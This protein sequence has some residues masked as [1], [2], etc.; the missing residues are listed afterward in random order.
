MSDASPSSHRPRFVVHSYDQ[1]VAALQAASSHDRAIE[2]LSATGAARAAGAGWWRELVE[3]ASAAVPGVDAV[4][5]LDCA[6]EPGLALAALREGVEAVS[7]DGDGP[8]WQRVADIARQS[9]A[10]LRRADH[11]GALDLARA[12]NPQQECE[13]HLGEAPDGVAKPRALG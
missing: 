11:A 2:I 4:W 10:D 3:Q 8:A 1:A 9:G 12:N 6:D 13:R 5:I 7:L